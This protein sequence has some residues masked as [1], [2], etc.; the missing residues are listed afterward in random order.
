MSRHPLAK[1]HVCVVPSAIS[2]AF[3]VYCGVM[4]RFSLSATFVSGGL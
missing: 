2:A 4:R 1:L 3:L